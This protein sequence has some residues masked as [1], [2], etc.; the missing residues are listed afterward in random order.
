VV[1]TIAAYWAT[2]T[3]GQEAFS[4]IN[5]KGL[6]NLSKLFHLRFG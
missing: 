2:Q 6:I 3:G 1:V 4:R 5:S